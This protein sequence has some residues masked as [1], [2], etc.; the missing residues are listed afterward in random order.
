MANGTDANTGRLKAALRRLLTGG[1]AGRSRALSRQ[2][3][4]IVTL[5]CADGMTAP[6]IA[7]ALDIPAEAVD[8]RLDDILAAV[9]ACG[10]AA[11]GRP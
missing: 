4:L 8:E 1:L 3:V 2:D 5:C 6:E 7:A 11:G 10:C 9:W